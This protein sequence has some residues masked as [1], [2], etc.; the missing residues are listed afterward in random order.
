MDE[1]YGPLN[2]CSLEEVRRGKLQL[3]A[4]TCEKKAVY[5]VLQLCLMRLS[6]M[7][8][9]SMEGTENATFRLR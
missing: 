3:P 7:V 4:V 9:R 8:R 1:G 5:R 2:E 6:K